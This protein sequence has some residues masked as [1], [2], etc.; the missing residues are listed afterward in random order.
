MRKSE[1]FHPLKIAFRVILLLGTIFVCDVYAVDIPTAAIS[2]VGAVRNAENR[3]IHQDRPDISTEIVVT[4]A[5]TASYLPPAATETFFV[6]RELVVDGSSI[7][8]R[9]DIAQLTNSSL[10]KRF[11]LA[12]FLAI[13]AKFKKAYD[14]AGY[15]VP[16][17]LVPVQNIKNGVARLQIQETNITQIKFFLDGAPTAPPP[18]LKEITDLVI[19]T[20]PLTR[21]VYGKAIDEIFRER[22]TLYVI[23]A[24]TFPSENG[25][26]SA[27]IDFTRNPKKRPPIGSLVIQP[28][29]DNT[30]PPPDAGRLRFHLKDILIT[31]VTAYDPAATKS[32]FNH[33]IG[34]EI[35]LADI[36]VIT[37]ALQEK[38]DADDY[39]KVQVIVPPQIVND[40][41]VKV[42]VNEYTVDKVVVTFNGNTANESNMLQ[43]IANQATHA[44]PLR[45]SDIS[46]YTKLMSDVPGVKVS[47]FTEPEGADGPVHISAERRKAYKGF[48]SFD[49]RG[50]GSIGPY[51]NE[52][53]LSFFSPFGFDDKMTIGTTFTTETQ[54]MLVFRIKEEL[55]LTP[56]GLTAFF[57]ASHTQ[58][59]PGAKISDYFMETLG[60]KFGIRLRYPLIRSSKFSWYGYG[61]FAYSDEMSTMLKGI[62]DMSNDQL[63]TAR[64]GNTFEFTD[65]YQG[66]NRINIEFSAGLN[67][68]D[69]EVTPDTMPNGY[70]PGLQPNY[71][72]LSLDISRDQPL[73]EKLSLSLGIAAQYGLTVIPGTELSAFGGSDYGRGYLSSIIYGDSGIMGKAELV[74]THEMGNDVLNALQPYAYYDTGRTWLKDLP[75]NSGMESI[76]NASSF[77]FGARFNLLNHV[78]ADLSFNQAL[79]E[80]LANSGRRSKDPLYLFNVRVDF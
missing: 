13:G 59:Q 49:N 61:H 65:K 76:M 29:L 55:P 35:A 6:L 31:G 18:E 16:E 30:A 7:L 19:H 33:I 43:R 64:I 1:K 27:K 48:V 37:A 8:N 62:Y 52:I 41:I 4:K 74:Y 24:Q 12:S 42:T 26:K 23:D 46:R 73:T 47:G 17:I 22:A 51:Q 60:D 57:S 14:D 25:D 68:L 75:Q 80:Y 78:T 44:R 56:E 40:G 66:S 34:Q 79:S 11:S 38:Y 58:I 72:K 50:T 39:T 3:S 15:L 54:E 77:G 71:R 9:D 53:G 45:N 10:N 32:L 20:H 36:F 5:I 2:P 63:R 21:Q 70:R 69:A 67:M 28:R